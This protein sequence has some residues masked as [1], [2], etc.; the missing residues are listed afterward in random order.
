MQ[1]DVARQAVEWQRH[2][3]E[4]VAV[5]ARQ[6]K[7][8]DSMWRALELATSADTTTRKVG[9]ALLREMSRS[10]QL[11]RDD[12]GRLFVAGQALVEPQAE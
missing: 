12:E 11:D 7:D 10:N 3:D 9:A 1:T 2:S 4:E 5:R 8:R 6:E